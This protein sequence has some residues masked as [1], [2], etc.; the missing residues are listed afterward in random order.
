MADDMS[1]DYV[2]RL[3]Q[4]EKQ[5]NQLLQVNRNFYDDVAEYLKLSESNEQQKT[6]I[7]KI[8]VGLFEKRR[9]K[10][11][12]Y[13]AYNKLLPQPTSEREQEFYK[14]I[15]QISEKYNI[16]FS[17]VQNRSNKLLRSINDIPEII[18]P[19]GK[20]FGPYKKGEIIEVQG[21]DVDGEYLLKNSICENYIR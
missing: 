20:K 2:W 3:F 6:N 19:S 7:E 15:V 14:E 18:L 9:Q 21:A 4:K 17:K 1:Y 12:L 13:A 16:A 11:L 8:L 10:I 5:T